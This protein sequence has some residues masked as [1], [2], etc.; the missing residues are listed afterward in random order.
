MKNLKASDW[1][2]VIDPV[3]SL[4]IIDNNFFTFVHTVNAD[5][6]VV[7]CGSGAKIF[8]NLTHDTSTRSYPKLSGNRKQLVVVSGDV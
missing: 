1:S 3:I 2:V 6:W 8:I 4:V 7:S 5:R